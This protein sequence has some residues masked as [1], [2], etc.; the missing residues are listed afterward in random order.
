MT[1]LIDKH[2]QAAP[3]TLAGGSPA[4]PP[5][6]QDPKLIAERT[7]RWKAIE[8]AGGVPSWV[9]AELKARG[10]LVEETNPSALSDKARGQFKERKKAEAT[11]RRA[12]KKLAWEAYTA[13]HITHLG[14]GIFWSDEEK[15]DAFD[16]AQRDARAQALKLEVTSVK[17]LAEAL[18]LT[19][20]TLR[21][22]AFHR[23]VDT[24]THYRR[25]KVLK[26][27]GVSTRTLASPKG[28]LKAAQRWVLRN[29]LEKLP[30]HAA[31]HGFL[32]ARS[33]VTNA[34]VHAG[35]PLVIK[36][37]IKDFFPSITWKR[38]KGL[39]RKQGLPENVATLLSLLATDAPREEVLFRGKTHYV[40]S[41]PRALPQGAPTSPALTNT[42]C[43][44]LDRRLSGLA[45]ALGF[46]YTRYAD[47][48]T[49]SWHPGPIQPGTSPQPGT[50]ALLRGIGQIL[51]AE[52]FRLNPAKTRIMRA[53]ERQAV[54]GLVINSAE[55]SA[56]ARVP[57]E[58]LRKLR[59]ALHNREQ[60]KPGKEGESLD[61][62]KGMAAFVYMTDP[63]KGKALLE[64]IEALVARN[65]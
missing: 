61:Q 58:T 32:S 53:G 45:R 50:G 11:E 10:L 63:A 16:H 34:Q 49:F 42:I 64:R 30:V 5:P 4:K 46:R 18:G 19:I 6:R 40:A 2:L 54:T 17:Q 38:V 25:W 8:A 13:T 21:W 35:S 15:A 48:L 56:A 51:E 33:I 28:Q 39:L 62:L 3:P 27:D 9:N 60:G 23:E 7:E 59:A 44:R 22:L 12:L 43:L 31:A 29:V 36:V 41:G 1:A 37:D 52:G 26:R 20:P 55:K 65:K 14:A 47:D 24:S 57:R